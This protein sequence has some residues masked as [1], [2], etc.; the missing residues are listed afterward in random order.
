[1]KKSL[2]IL[3]A[4]F[5]L[6]VAC[7]ETDAEE[8]V[9]PDPE[10]EPQEVV[11]TEPEPEPEPATDD[12]EELLL[13]EGEWESTD[14]LFPKK[15]TIEDG[16][17]IIYDVYD[18][19]TSLYWVGTA[20]ETVSEGETFISDGDVGRMENALLASTLEEKE[21]TLEDGRL[22]YQQGFMDVETTVRLEKQDS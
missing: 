9:T 1:M 14:D 15:V 20:P 6:L 7:G 2:A 13:L 4:L 18:D 3:L 17:I 19:T 21:F 16:E 10:P 22:V 5:V 12:N 8:I 11:E